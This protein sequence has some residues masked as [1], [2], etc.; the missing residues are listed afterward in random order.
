ME[1]K[2]QLAYKITMDIVNKIE[3]GFYGDNNMFDEHSLLDDFEDIHEDL[4]AYND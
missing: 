3:S 2:Q 4:L 1:G